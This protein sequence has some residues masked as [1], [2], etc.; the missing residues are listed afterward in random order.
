[1]ILEGLADASKRE[2]G[3][4][5]D[6]F[7]TNRAKSNE[8]VESLVG[9]KGAVDKLKGERAQAEVSIKYVLAKG[10]LDPTGLPGLGDG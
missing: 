7:D 5:N 4:V 2:I 9:V 8:V 1:V 6:T 10:S 3:K